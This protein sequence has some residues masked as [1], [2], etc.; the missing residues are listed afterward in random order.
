MLLLSKMWASSDVEEDAI[1]RFAVMTRGSKTRKSVEVSSDRYTVSDD[2]FW[3][4]LDSSKHNRWFLMIQAPCEYHLL[5]CTHGYREDVLFAPVMRPLSGLY[6]LIQSKRSFSII[7]LLRNLNCYRNYRVELLE[8]RR[9]V[10][11][12]PSQSVPHWMRSGSTPPSNR[13][14]FC[15]PIGPIVEIIGITSLIS[16]VCSRSDSLGCMQRVWGI[17]RVRLHLLSYLDPTLQ[18]RIWLPQTARRCV[19]L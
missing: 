16:T 13:M 11:V 1:L 14:M 15:M 17:N 3:K 10:T 8:L 4:E 6:R 18:E 9:S 5:G 7:S 19:R 12:S 2:P